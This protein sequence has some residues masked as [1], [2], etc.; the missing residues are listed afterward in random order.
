MVERMKINDVELAYELTGNG[1]ETVIFLNGIAM[2]IVHWKLFGEALSSCRC[3]AHD[4]R[5]QIL[6][7]RP[8]ERY[9]LA[10]QANDLWEMLKALGIDRVHVVGTSYGSAVGF[11]LYL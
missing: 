5:G 7:G 10:G 1:N 11:Y 3:L 8:A 2:S 6:S 4:F 9:T